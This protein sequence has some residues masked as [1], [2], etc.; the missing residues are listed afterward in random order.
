MS[1]VALQSFGILFQPG[2]TGSC[3]C[4][5]FLSKDARLGDASRYV[6]RNVGQ[7]PPSVDQ[8]VSSRPAALSLAPGS[9]VW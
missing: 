4:H 5:V 1:G 7:F 2:S 9:V 8:A 6:F 3:R